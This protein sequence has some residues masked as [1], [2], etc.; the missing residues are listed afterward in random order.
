MIV[1]AVGTFVAG[2]DE[3]VAAVDRACSEL[4]LEGF[5]QIGH[6]RL[7]PAKIGWQRFLPQEELVARFMASRVVVC[8]AGMGIVGEA[9]RARVPIVLFP[10]TGATCPD[11]PANDQA[12]FARR[13]AGRHGLAVCAEGA[14]LARI[15]AQLLALPARPAYRLGSD[16]PEI[17]GDW[18]A[19][20]RAP[21]SRGWR[22]R[23]GAPSRSTDRTAATRSIIAG[24]CSRKH[25]AAPEDGLPCATC[26]IQPG[27]GKAGR[28]RPVVQ[29]WPAIMGCIRTGCSWLEHFRFS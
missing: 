13:I 15:L 19:Q 3:L 8:H 7:L 17:L 27:P 18:L 24:S 21:R 16:I 20:A 25:V 29:A 26:A 10:R 22:E 14:D 2:F 12:A 23:M 4:D 9:M 11:H 28:D 1:A 6:G 5:A